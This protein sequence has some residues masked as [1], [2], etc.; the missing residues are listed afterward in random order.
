MAINWNGGC[1]EGGGAIYTAGPGIQINS[2]NEISADVRRDMITV[3]EVS[4]A[5]SVH[6]VD[7]YLIYNNGLYRVIAAI[8]AGDTLTPDVNIVKTDVGTELGRKLTKPTVVTTAPY[9][10]NCYALSGQIVKYD[11]LVVATIN[12]TLDAAK[13]AETSLFGIGYV[14]QGLHDAYCGAAFAAP[15]GAK[16]YYRMRYLRLYTMFL[17]MDPMPAGSYYFYLVGLTEE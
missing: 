7:E 3:P 16:D 9:N 13:P 6:A 17:T 12:F 8:A 1:G 2:Q 14:L 15:Y 4:P 10:W 5:E 11:R